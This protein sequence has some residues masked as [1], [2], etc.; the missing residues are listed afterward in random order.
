MIRQRLVEASE[1][2]TTRNG[3]VH[4]VFAAGTGVKAEAG[5]PH[6]LALRYRE[7]SMRMRSEEIKP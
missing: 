1:V 2:G 3:M 7:A 6:S 4:A 5:N